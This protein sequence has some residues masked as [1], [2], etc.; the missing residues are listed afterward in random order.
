MM[1]MWKR[2][3]T[4]RAAQRRNQCL[5]ILIV[6]L[7]KIPVIVSDFNSMSLISSHQQRS[8]S[9]YLTI[10]WIMDLAQSLSKTDSATLQI[11]M[12]CLVRDNR[13]NS[14]GVISRTLTGFSVISLLKWSISTTEALIFK[15]PSISYLIMAKIHQTKIST[16]IIR[17]MIT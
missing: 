10:A 9:K 5:Y 6:L 1:T 11:T 2:K 17:D 7:V 14:M 12:W 16:K 8:L 4:M 15:T 13:S 3:L